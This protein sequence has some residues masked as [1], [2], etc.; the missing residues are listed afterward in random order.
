MRYAYV[1]GCVCVYADVFSGCVRVMS[2]YCVEYAYVCGCVCVYADVFSGCVRV[3][4]VY[5]VVLMMMS[6]VVEL[7]VVVC[8]RYDV[9]GV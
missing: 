9:G 6:M 7:R 4:S 1:C 2:V 5:C 8:W 3:M